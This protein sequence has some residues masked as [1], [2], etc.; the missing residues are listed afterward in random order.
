MADVAIV[1]GSPSATPLPD[2]TLSK[3]DGWAMSVETAR[4]LVATIQAAIRD[5]EEGDRT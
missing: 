5:V 4:Q 2:A 3:I 1:V